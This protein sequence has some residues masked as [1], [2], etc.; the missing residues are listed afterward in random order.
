LVLLLD[1]AKDWYCETERIYTVGL[2]EAAESEA[3]RETDRAPRQQSKGESPK[4][5]VPGEESPE[6]GPAR[7]H[8]KKKYRWQQKFH[9]RRGRV[10]DRRAVLW[11][12]PKR[13]GRRAGI[14]R[15]VPA[16]QRHH[17]LNQSRTLFGPHCA[18]GRPGPQ[19]G[20]QEQAD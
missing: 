10:A 16:S 8:E 19:V 1:E 11:L 15:P 13:V 4:E 6:A 14:Y 17:F 18:G 12:Y 7:G 2:H 3:P 9:P 5:E 20:R